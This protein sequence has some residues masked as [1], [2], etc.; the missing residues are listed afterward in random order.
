MSELWNYRH[1]IEVNDVDLV[2]YDVEATDGR[3]GKIDESSAEVGSAHL[4]VDTG[5]WIFGHKRVLPAR[6]V[7][8]INHD[9]QVVFIDL[10]KDEVKGA[11]DHHDTWSGPDD[12]EPFTDYYTPFQW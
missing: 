4:V 10:T 5:F 11:P 12:R 1:D 3:I 2:G 7:K 8:Q 6:A 9:D